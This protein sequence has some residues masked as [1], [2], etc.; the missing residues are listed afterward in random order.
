MD[1]DYAIQMDNTK[2]HVS[3][4]QQL[5]LNPGSNCNNASICK[6]TTQSNGK[7]T[8]TVSIKKSFK[9]SLLI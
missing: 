4:C 1:Y 7:E 2:Y 9:S 6:I 8:V 3:I 5:K